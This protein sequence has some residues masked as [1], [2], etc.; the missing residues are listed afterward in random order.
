MKSL[1][2]GGR[3]ASRVSI[4]QHPTESVWLTVDSK[5]RTATLRMTQQN[6]GFTL[7]LKLALDDWNGIK[8]S[9]I[10]FGNADNGQKPVVAPQR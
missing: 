8:L 10:R 6:Q 7:A 5:Q 9:K 4:P 3:N 1:S 2:Q